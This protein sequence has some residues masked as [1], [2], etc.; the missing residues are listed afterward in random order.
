M[1]ALTSSQSYSWHQVLFMYV[2]LQSF[3]ILLSVY[4]PRSCSEAL[5][6]LKPT[7]SRLSLAGPCLMF[8][9][10]TFCLPLWFFYIDTGHWMSHTVFCD[11]IC[12]TQKIWEFTYCTTKL[13][14]LGDKTQG[15][16][17]SFW[18]LLGSLSRYS[19]N[20]TFRGQLNEIYFMD[21]SSITHPHIVSCFLSQFP[22]P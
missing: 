19:I 2:R 9:P 12:E 18:P 15:I 20:K 8:V 16:D 11:C 21:S 6:G 13:W 7:S 5:R 3:L 17:S 22:F 14:S 10:W 1:N 4:S